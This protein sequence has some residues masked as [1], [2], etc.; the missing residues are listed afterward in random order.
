MTGPNEAWVSDLTYIR[1]DEGFL[2]AALI[3]D[4]YSRKI[5]GAHI[6]DSLEAE[7]CL[8]ALEQALKSLRKGSIPS[9]IRIGDVSIA[10]T[11]MWSG[12][13]REGCRSA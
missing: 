8:E 4:V 9:T 1:T 5:V 2:Y 6:G 10:A 13:R 11:H 7:G 12:C 3:T